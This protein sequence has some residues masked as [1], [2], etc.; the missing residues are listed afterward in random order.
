MT[1]SELINYCETNNLLDYDVAVE[2][3]MLD[4]N[5]INVSDGTANLSVN[6]SILG[7]SCSYIYNGELMNGYIFGYRY[8]YCLIVSIT[9]DIVIALKKSNIII[10]D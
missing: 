5:M 7:K 10:N 6:N 8:D 1:F 3:K 2:D 4:I 9:K